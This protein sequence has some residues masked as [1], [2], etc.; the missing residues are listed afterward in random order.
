MSDKKFTGFL[1][2][3]SLGGVFFLIPVVILG[4]IIV[5]AAGFMMAVAQPMADWLPIDTIGGVALANIIAAL[6]LVLVCFLA[7]IIARHAFAS[8]F[9]NRLESK[10][11]VNVPGYL[12]IKS[13]VSGFDPSKTEGLQPVAVQL[14]S[15]ER[16]GFEIERSQDGRCVVFIPGAPNPYS[17]ITQVLPADQV[18]YL[19][20]SLKEVIEVAENFG[21]GV[22]RILA[23]KKQ[24]D[25]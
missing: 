10:V 19:D 9:V 3:T 14:G 20:V 12:M 2:T 7:G 11:L 17:G 13:L 4:V 24:A 21:H 23:R 5:K 8:A 6:A 16:V 25:T 15:A 22:H 1:I 18:T